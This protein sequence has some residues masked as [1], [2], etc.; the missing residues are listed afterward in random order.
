MS[1]RVA[2]LRGIN[3]GRAKRVPMAELRELAAELGFTDV[4]TH[5]Q[6]GNLLYDS[7]DSADDDRQRLTTAL[8]RRFGLPID[9]VVV[10]G[11]RLVRLLEEHP[12]ADG[13]PKL[14]HVGFASGPLPQNLRQELESRAGESERFQVQEDVL[15]AD[16]GS[17]V[18]GSSAA[19]ALPRL[20]RPGFITLR[21]LTTLRAL[22]SKTT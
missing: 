20:V 3:V 6:S 13:N 19:N 14:V 18:H 4:T 15:Y 10:E 9:V 17:G 11:R 22:V 12:F 21:N 7:Q 16:F 8:E 1:T 2:L 5:L